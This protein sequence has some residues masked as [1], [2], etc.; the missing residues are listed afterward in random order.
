VPPDD[1]TPV[2]S[3][4]QAGP[5]PDWYLEQLRVPETVVGPDGNQDFSYASMGDLLLGGAVTNDGIRVDVGLLVHDGGVVAQLSRSAAATLS[6][7][8]GMPWLAER[9]G[10]R[11]VPDGDAGPVTAAPDRSWVQAAQ[12]P[13][14][15]LVLRPQEG[16]TVHV[17]LGRLPETLRF[18]L[19]LIGTL[20]LDLVLGDEPLLATLT[21]RGLAALAAESRAWSASVAATDGG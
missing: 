17:G 11:P 5:E 20:R 13:N 8:R 16:S 19:A 2:A 4:H 9:W 12:G 3:G 1:A 14:A 18:Q 15:V 6:G 21:G 10:L 7:S